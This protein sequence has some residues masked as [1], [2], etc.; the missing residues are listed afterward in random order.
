VTSAELVASRSI[1]RT[2]EALGVRSDLLSPILAN[3]A[4][5]GGGGA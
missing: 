4:A 2:D 3:A 1:A 5:A